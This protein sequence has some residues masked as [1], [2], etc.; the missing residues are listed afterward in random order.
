MPVPLLYSP[1]DILFY[2][3]KPGDM[4][5][6]LI[7]DITA[8]PFV[9]VGIA[10]SGMQEIQ[11]LFHGVLLTGID[12]EPDVWSYSQN[13]INPDPARMLSALA[14]LHSMCGRAYGWDDIG[15]ALLAKLR[16]GLSIDI[17]DN[18]D[19][20]ALACDFLLRAGAVP[21][22][23]DN[24]DPHEVTPGILAARLGIKP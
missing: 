24:P 9:H 23:F 21:A 6:T 22:L 3:R 2:R 8:S 15:N 5:D 17:S 12:P 11:A 14:W 16:L 1:G 20:S 7:S 19:C 13:A 18:L 4:V 10:I